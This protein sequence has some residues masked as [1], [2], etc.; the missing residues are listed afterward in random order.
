MKELCLSTRLLWGAD[1][2]EA[3][4]EWKGKR[5][6]VV[7]DQFL[8]KSGMLQKVLDHLKESTVEVFD[9]VAGEPTLPIVAQAV[10]CQRS[11]GGEGVVAFGGGSAMDCG[12]AMIHFSG[13]PIPLWCVPTTAGT[14]SEV[15][16]FAVVTDPKSGVKYPIVEKGL[17]P[18]T[19]L[20][21][22]QFLAGVPQTVTADTGLD[23]LTHVT[24]AYVSVRANAFTDALSTKGFS[25]V[26]ECLPDAYGGCPKAKNKMLLA[27]S[28]AG[29]AFNAAGLG[30]CHSL[31]HALGG[32]LHAPHG[33]VNAVLL[34]YVI[35]KNGT[36]PKAARK[37]GQ[38]AKLWGLAPTARSLA[39]AIRRLNRRLGL[40]EKLSGKADVA[41][42]VQD[43]LRDRCTGDNPVAFTARELESLLREVID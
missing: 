12:K 18:H 2:L 29:M 3:L 38:L 32:R 20:L 16:S 10:A 17:L 42:V 36:D 23:V 24:E 25:L 33:R 40:P 7:A 9:S 19:A 35:E 37:Y 14:G 1:A 6:L 22:G 15:T 8:S 26:G 39:G 4:G 30:I 5:V 11:F 21:D 27:S 13:K 28:L 31:A 41:A 43:A 34:P